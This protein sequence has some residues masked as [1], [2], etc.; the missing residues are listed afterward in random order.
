MSLRLHDWFVVEMYFVI[1]DNRLT[2][3]LIIR[4][5]FLKFHK[6]FRKPT[7]KLSNNARAVYKISKDKITE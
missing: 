3:M 7:C 1:F 6:V 2:N 4:I 5:I